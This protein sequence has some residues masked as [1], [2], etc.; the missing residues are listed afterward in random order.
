M[1]ADSIIATIAKLITNI[2]PP[3][4]MYGNDA[5]LNDTIDSG[6]I[7]LA[8]SLEDQVQGLCMLINILLK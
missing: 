7:S 2:I 4:M 3:K 1:F 6:I 8:S 5:L